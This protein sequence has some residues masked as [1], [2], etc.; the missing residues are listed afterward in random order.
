V[1]ALDWR[2]LL[3]PQEVEHWISANQRCEEIGGC[4]PAVQ[5]IEPTDPVKISGTAE[6]KGDGETQSWSKPFGQQKDGLF[7]SQFRGVGHKREEHMD[8]CKR[9]SGYARMHLVFFDGL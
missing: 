7:D 1:A 9:D 3:A 5:I 6:I 4:T 8:R 2:A